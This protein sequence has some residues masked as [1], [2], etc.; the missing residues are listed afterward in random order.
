MRTAPDH[1]TGFADADTHLATLVSD[2]DNRAETHL[3][4]AFHSLGDPADLDHA[5]LPFGVALLVAAV[6]ATATATVS[7]VTTSAATAALLLLSF[8]RCRDISR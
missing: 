4:T 5:L 6:T 1:I 7:A 2:D 8:G 3:L